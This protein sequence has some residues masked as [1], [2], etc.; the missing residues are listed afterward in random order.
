MRWLLPLLLGCLAAG[1]PLV[2]RGFPAE[3]AARAVQQ[4]L[5]IALRL[6][7]ALR[8]RSVWF[9]L[10]RPDAAAARQALAIAADGWWVE[11]LIAPTPTLPEAP[12][13]VRSYPPLPATP[14]EAE[15][16]AARM[17]APWLA[18]GGGLALDLFSG[19]WTASL[20]AAG[21]ARLLALLAALGAPAP[22]APHWVV[23]RRAPPPFT[24]P[25]AGADRFAW[26]QALA[27]ATGWAVALA[28][29]AEAH[30]PP[31]P[32]AADADAALAALRNEGL[33]VELHHGCLAIG[34]AA[35]G[36]RLHPAWRAEVA[37]LPAAHLAPDA[38]ALQRLAEAL[39][40][41]VE[42][43]AWTAPGW[44]L[45]PLPERRSLLAVADAATIHA[46][47]ARLEVWERAAAP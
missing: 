15:A 40:A 19:T 38:A 37:L 45:A 39:R 5:G 43:A 33:A 12:L 24:E 1:E 13:I 27:S 31:P 14:R 18:Q 35:S 20:P 8:P 47:L 42:P 30:A 22:R 46:V 26:C 11:E 25:V 4:R 3:L 28:P 21:Q 41:E 9:V 32:P 16:L 10:P 23:E 17:L 6:D 34:R 29:G 2:C 36:D 44:L 7:P